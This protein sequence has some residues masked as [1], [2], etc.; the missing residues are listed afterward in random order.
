[1]DSKINTLDLVDTVTDLGNHFKSI[2]AMLEIIE[3]EYY[4]DGHLDPL[5]AVEVRDGKIGK[6]HEDYPLA[7]LTD[8]ICWEYPKFMTYLQIITEFV[9]QGLDVTTQVKRDYLDSRTDLY[10]E[11]AK[12]DNVAM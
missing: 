4:R 8:K 11:R 2:S 7:A 10:P 6:G 12:T 3:S 9:N 5:G 1:M